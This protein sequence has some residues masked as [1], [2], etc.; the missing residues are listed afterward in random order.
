ML[1]T[2]ANGFISFLSQW[3]H[4]WRS[5]YHLKHYP[6]QEVW[7]IVHSALEVSLSKPDSGRSFHAFIDLRS[8][9]WEIFLPLRCSGG[10]GDIFWVI[11]Q[12][13]GTNKLPLLNHLSKITNLQGCCTIADPAL[14]CAEL[15]FTVM[16]KYV[17]NK[18]ILP[19]IVLRPSYTECCRVVKATRGYLFAIKAGD[20]LQYEQQQLSVTW[21]GCVQQWE[22][23]QWEWRQ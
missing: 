17:K 23:S 2:G 18:G 21:C 5:I 7:K 10:S 22:K 20:V 11:A 14:L 12:N 6:I 16:C 9:L 13:P 15:N 3:K 1:Q 4:W 19:L 8:L